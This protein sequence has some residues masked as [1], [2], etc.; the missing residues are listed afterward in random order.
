M[1]QGEE[2]LTSWRL[3]ADPEATSPSLK[4]TYRYISVATTLALLRPEE[5]NLFM[6]VMVENQLEVQQSLCFA[7]LLYTWAEQSSMASD[8]KKPMHRKR[9]SLSRV[10]VGY[11]QGNERRFKLVLSVRKKTAENLAHDSPP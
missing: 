9:S 1:P 6:R 5:A 3:S 8:R 11:Q 4:G 2:V 10:E 7:D